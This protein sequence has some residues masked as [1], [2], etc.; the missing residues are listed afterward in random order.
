MSVVKA[1][2]TFLRECPLLNVSSA[3]DVMIGVDYLGDDT[4]TYSLE[5]VPTNNIVK[6]YIDGSSIRQA[7]FLFR[8]REPYGP[9]LMQQLDNSGFY[10]DF[11]EWLERCTKKGDLPILDEGKEAQS[12]EALTCG[13]A[14][15]T[16]ADNAIYQIQI[17]F[18][19]YQGV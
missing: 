1:V 10:E 4:T 3:G 17:N 6:S 15:N 8:S 14:Y 18:K 9:D 2:R 12:I 16:D 11:S 19:Y 13:Y 5:E 7:T